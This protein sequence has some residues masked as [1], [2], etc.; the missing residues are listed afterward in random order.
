MNAEYQRRFRER[1]RNPEEAARIQRKG[2]RL[3]AKKYRAESLVA[4]GMTASAAALKLGCSHH[5][6]LRHL[7]TPEARRRVG[8]LM[9]DTGEPEQPR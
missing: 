2:W 6:L 7:S 5:T 8:L 9:R 1:H 3:D 4:D